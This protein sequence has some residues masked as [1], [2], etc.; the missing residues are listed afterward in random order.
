MTY[1]PS[2]K[3]LD[4]YADLLVNFALN[5][6]KG[7]R[8]E[9]VILVQVPECAKPM[10]VSLQRTILKA[11]AQMSIQYLPDGLSREFYQLASDK[12]IT[13]FPAEYMKARINTID[14]SIYIIAE[15]DLHELEGINPK[16]LMARQKSW[17]PYIEWKDEK[18]NKG[19]FTWNLAV[20]GT[21]AMA[22]EAKMSLKEYW[23]QIIKAC[24]L[25]YPNPTAKWKY[26]YREL[27]RIRSRL[28]K[29]KIEKVH[30]KS[31]NIDL[32]IGIGKNRIWKGGDG[33][34]IPGFEIYTTPS[35]EKVDG[36][37]RFNVPLYSAGNLIEGIGLEFKDGKIV[38]ATAKKNE[39][40]LRELIKTPGADHIGEFSMTDNRLSRITKFMAE[41]LYDENRGGKYG[42]SHIAL[43]RAI[44]DTYPGN[45]DNVSKQQ[46]KKMGYNDSVIHTDIFSTEDRTVTATLENGKEIVIYRKGRFTI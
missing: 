23:K 39:R 1:Q 18:E 34:N 43:G 31:N 4:K 2:Q 9:E 25:D 11:K 37:I 27:H 10:L 44:R 46:W 24:Y 28:D 42:N 36:Y 35:R 30:I 26:V 45:K 32:M 29:L 5:S 41:T 6:G 19:K 13:F 40:F 21:E 16:K 20:Y 7:V 8:P 17:K 15:S 3:I 33:R 22:K 14:H 12:Q 38:K